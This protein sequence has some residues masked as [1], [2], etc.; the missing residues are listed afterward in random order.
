MGSGQG[1]LGP[2]FILSGLGWGQ[3]LTVRRVVPRPSSKSVP[4]LAGSSVLPICWEMGAHLTVCL[5]AG[6]G[7]LGRAGLLAWKTV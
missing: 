1:S 3:G 2:G 5:A 6:G 7:H 4:A